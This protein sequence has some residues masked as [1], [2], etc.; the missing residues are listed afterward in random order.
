[1]DGKYLS[2]LLLQ[3]RAQ[4]TRPAKVNMYRLVITVGMD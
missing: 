2:I 1:M 3:I 4:L